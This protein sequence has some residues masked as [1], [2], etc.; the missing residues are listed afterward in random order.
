MVSDSKAAAGIAPLAARSDRFTA[1][2]FHADAVGGIAGQEMH[3]LGDGVVGD[4]QPLEQRRVVHQPARRGVG[5]EPA[6]PR[7][8]LGLVHHSAGAARA[9][10]AMASSRPLTK[11]LSRLS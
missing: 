6:Q 11:P 1:T 3:A 8:R 5:R 2:S 4:D 9:S 7:N 10:L